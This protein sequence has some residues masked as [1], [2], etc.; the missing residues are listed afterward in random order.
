MILNFGRRRAYRQK[1][2]SSHVMQ[3]CLF[4]V[5]SYFF[6]FDYFWLLPAVRKGRA[7]ALENSFLC[8]SDT[9]ETVP[10][11]RINVTG[12]TRCFLLPPFIEDPLSF[13]WD[14]RTS[15]ME[16]YGSAEPLA[17]QMPDVSTTADSSPS[18][19]L[20]IWFFQRL[21]FHLMQPTTPHPQHLTV[22]MKSLWACTLLKL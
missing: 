5:S 14:P 20:A 9:V 12:T 10:I 7:I 6:C 8:W 3:L 18:A 16:I 11:S 22:D 17:P 2:F 13:R 15:C 1:S 4:W 19:V 21:L